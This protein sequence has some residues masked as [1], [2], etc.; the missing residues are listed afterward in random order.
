[1]RTAGPQ[2]NTIRQADT[3]LGNVY[4]YFFIEGRDMET[5]IVV[6]KRIG[7]DVNA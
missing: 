2:D 6:V 5:A 4:Y 3:L 7:K 1:M